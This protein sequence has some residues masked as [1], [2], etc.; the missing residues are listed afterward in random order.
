MQ[1][2]GRKPVQIPDAKCHPKKNGKSVRA[3]GEQENGCKKE[4]K[5]QTKRE[6]NKEIEEMNDA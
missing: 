4:D 3:W 2:L 5:Q 6:I 1:P